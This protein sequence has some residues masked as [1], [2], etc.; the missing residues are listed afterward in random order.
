MNLHLHKLDVLKLICAKY[1]ILYD[2]IKDENNVT[3]DIVFKDKDVC[4]TWESK[5][6]EVTNKES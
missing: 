2:E 6:F 3:V 5:G 4:I 1:N